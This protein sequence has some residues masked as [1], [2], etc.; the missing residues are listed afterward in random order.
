[1]AP[2]MHMVHIHSQL[3]KIP[4]HIKKIQ[5]TSCVWPFSTQQFSSPFSHYTATGWG[6]GSP[7]H[8]SHKSHEQNKLLYKV[9]R[10]RY[11]ITI[12]CELVPLLSQYYLP[13][14]MEHMK[15]HVCVCVHTLSPCIYSST[16]MSSTYLAFLSLG[17]KKG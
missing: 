6:L 13:H 11:V 10:L 3:G 9:S 7:K 1:M 15:M 4:I 5:T 8:K 2:D 16:W 17:L 14:N 12:K